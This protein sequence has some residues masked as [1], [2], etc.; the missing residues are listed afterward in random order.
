MSKLT[1]DINRIFIFL[2]D[3]TVLS[4]DK[5]KLIDKN[6]NLIIGNI[7][8]VTDINSYIDIISVSGI[9]DLMV[10]WTEVFD[11]RLTYLATP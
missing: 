9:N 2:Y 10:G 5:S 3:N 6:W 1:I 4:D 7:K 8:S 11:D